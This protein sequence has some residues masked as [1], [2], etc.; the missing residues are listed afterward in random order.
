MNLTAILSIITILLFLASLGFVVPI[1]IVKKNRKNAEID[2]NFDINKDKLLVLKKA[3]VMLRSDNVSMSFDDDESTYAM[4]SRLKYFLLKKTNNYS[5]INFPRAWLMIGLLDYY[6]AHKDESILNEVILS[7]DK[8][9]DD[10]GSLSFEF[11]NIDQCLFGVVF[12]R[13]YLILNKDKYAISSHQ[14][15]KEI[16]SFLDT[17]GVYFY[18][19]N[20]KVYFV[21]TIGMVCPFLYLY[22]TVFNVRE[23]KD[24]ASLQ[25]DYWINFLMGNGHILP[26]HAYD[27]E[28]K[29]PLGSCNWSRGIAWFMIGLSYGVK[30]E[31]ETLRP[32]LVKKNNELLDKLAT[33]QKNH[34]GWGQFLGHDNSNK[35]DASSTIMFL[36]AQKISGER[37]FDLAKYSLKRCINSDGYIVSNSGDTIYINKY[38]RALDK[39]EVSQGLFLTLLEEY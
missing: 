29:I 14:V 20:S 1:Y 25:L 32:A 17:N 34:G 10:S 4:M 3:M 21:D 2:H 28:N 18:R 33:L 38:S 6:E 9:I 13:L 12:L 31:S 19:K 15:Y 39:S 11:N 36:Y 8:L 16:Q 30:Y 37:V 27:I 22:S 35:I 5:Y 26:Y 24:S 7:V 23:A